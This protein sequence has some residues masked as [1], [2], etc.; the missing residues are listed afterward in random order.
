VDTPN[1]ALKPLLDH[2]A[3]GL[4]VSFVEQMEEIPPSGE[5]L[6]QEGGK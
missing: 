5:T 3:S 2:I 4:A 1:V 6:E